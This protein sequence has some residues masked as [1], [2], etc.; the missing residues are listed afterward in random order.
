MCVICV[1]YI[2]MDNLIN[3]NQYKKRTNLLTKYITRGGKMKQAKFINHKK[4]LSQ[5]GF[6]VAYVHTLESAAYTHSIE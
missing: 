1:L 4:K 5:N 6:P 3:R 2:Y